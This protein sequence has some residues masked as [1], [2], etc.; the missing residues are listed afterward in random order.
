MTPKD[1]I[2]RDHTVAFVVAKFNVPTRDGVDG[3]TDMLLEAW[4]IAPVPGDPADP[5]YDERVI[6]FEMPLVF[7]LG[8]VRADHDG[9]AGGVITFPV[10]VT[11]FVRG[12]IRETVLR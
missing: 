4:H 1:P 9:T 2:L 12:S 7:A 11:D 3:H 10:T 6:D 8:I 5:E